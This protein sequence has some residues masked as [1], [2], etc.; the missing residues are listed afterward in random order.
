MNKLI[1]FLALVTLPALGADPDNVLCTL[2][3]KSR[4]VQI[5]R[6]AGLQV[7]C[8]VHYD[9]D[10]YAPGDPMVLWRARHEV[11]FC[12]AKAAELIARLESLGWACAEDLKK[13][14]QNEAAELEPVG[15]IEISE[16]ES[17]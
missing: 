15:E 9:R 1:P 2:E 3:D 16:T 13:R 6:D 10:T 17:D 5:V 4:R 8:E 12:E 7:P 14:D 11:G